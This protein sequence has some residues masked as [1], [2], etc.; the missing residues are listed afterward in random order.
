MDLQLAGRRT[1]VTGAS[2]GIGLEIA[3][4]LALEGGSVAICAREEG[5]LSEAADQLRSKGATV[6]AESVDVTDEGE[7]SAFVLSLIHI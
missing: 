6:F 4:T 2:R 5:P 3:R 1:L 7:L